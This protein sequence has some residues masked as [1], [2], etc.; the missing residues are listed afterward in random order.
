MNL[1][2]KFRQQ[3]LM[4]T[5]LMM[6]TLSVGILI[7]TL[8]NT[9][10]HAAKGQSVA[11]DAT[12]LTVP[13]A[14][15]SSNEFTKLAKRL[16]PSVVNITVEVAP[17]AEQEGVLS[18]PQSRNRRQK[19]KQAPNQGEEGEEGNPLRQ[20]FGNGAPE[21][22]PQSHEV[23]GTGF[24]VD[25]NGYIVTNNH[26][27]EDAAKIMVKLLGDSKEY[28]GRIVGVDQETDLAVIKIDAGTP[29]Q[30]VTIGNS[31]AVQVGD[32]AIAV[33]SPFQLDETVT[34]GIVS[35]TGRGLDQMQP[36]GNTKAFQ[37]FIQTDAAINPG[38]SGGPLVN[39]R[40]EVIGV[41][42]MIATS[43][44]GSE[45]V[46]FA[47]P[48]NMVVRVYNDIIREGRVIRGS[49]GI[50]FPT[51]IKPELLRGL[52]LDH[53]V[54]IDSVRKGGPAEKGGLKAEDIIT[55]INGQVVK[56]GDDLMGRVSDT[57]VG[58]PLTL[59]V[60][61]DG[62]KMDFKVVTQDR[63]EL[64]S[65]RSD[66]VSKTFAPETG[67]SET[68]NPVKFGIIPRALTD[69][70]RSLTTDK[71]GISVQRVDEDS[72]AEEI[73]L[74]EHDIVTAINRQPVNSP[75]DVRKVAQSLKPGDA[76]TFRVLRS[77][78]GNGVR[79]VAR[80]QAGEP[81]T[82]VKYLAGTARN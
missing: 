44:G 59:T 35:A 8:V 74:M 36:Y 30:A 63:M 9:Q 43:N 76:V 65:D 39:I 68:G 47:M 22:A 28:R 75:D 82:L 11:P 72:F 21:V 51:E 7:G 60:D 61:R 78:R 4:S 69:D 10:V 19:Q 20:W 18:E 29:L 23:S 80:Q 13:R 67:K 58:N 64:Y 32:W 25:K 5:T 55:A 38:N 66:I 46:G 52:G 45:G 34:L 77:S 24:I 50:L 6:F 37:K 79:G 70:E 54:L 42:T 81:E 40:G 53:G 33:G 49:I 17:K 16:E 31:D 41:N 73:G 15:D 3:K 14:V 27:V 48:S 26:V 56:D 12:P 1:F 2:D 57:P 62:K 71:R